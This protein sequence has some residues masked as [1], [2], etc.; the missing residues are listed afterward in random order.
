MAAATPATGRFGAALPALGE[1]KSVAAGLPDLLIEAR[2]VAATVVAGWHGRRVAGRGE[3][4][5]Q[6]R[7]FS[8]G[9]AAVGIDWRRSARDEHFYVREKEWE[10]AH[11]VWLWPDISVSMDFRSRLARASKR[12]RALVMVLALADLLGGAGERIG[13]L[14]ESDPILAHNAAER[15]AAFIGRM[16][17]RPP[18][19]RRL[20]RFTDV[21]LVSDFLDP[22][23]EVEARLDAIVRSGARAHLVQVTDPVEETFPFAGRTEFED[24]ETGLRHVVGRAEQYRGEYLA[25]L[26]ALREQLS[27]LCRRLDWTFLVHRT[28][29][30]ASEP[31]LALHARL[32]DRQ[33]LAGGYPGGRAA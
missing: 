26:A 27:L 5:W 30:P 15:I 29:R 24:P 19:T 13:L 4:F 16:T 8:T 25:R 9:E 2:R 3:T 28:D 11:L 17:P 18:D 20:R 10:A 6:F 32:A 22:M 12:D 23:A 14:G 31:L 1:A 33:A 7:Q 21:V